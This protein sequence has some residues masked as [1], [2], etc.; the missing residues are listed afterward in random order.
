[1]T[2]PAMVSMTAEPPVLAVAELAGAVVALAMMAV[3][4]TAMATARVVV[5]A[6][7]TMVVGDLAVLI[8]TTATVVAARPPLGCPSDSRCFGPVPDRGRK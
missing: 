4:E 1:M 7:M 2:A 6:V 8:S 5:L 3:V